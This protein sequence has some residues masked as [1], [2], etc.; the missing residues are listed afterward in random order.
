MFYVVS[1]NCVN[2]TKLVIIFK[3]IIILHALFT[4]KRPYHNDRND[5]HPISYTKN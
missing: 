2:S 4:K 5:L 1:F 3:S